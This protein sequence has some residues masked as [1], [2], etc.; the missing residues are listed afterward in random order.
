MIE[1]EKKIQK[2]KVNSYFPPFLEGFNTKKIKTTFDDINLEVVSI[3]ALKLLEKIANEKETLSETIIRLVENYLLLINLSKIYNILFYD[4]LQHQTHS[5]LEKMKTVYTKRLSGYNADFIEQLDVLIGDEL[6]SGKEQA[7][8]RKQLEKSSTDKP[9]VSNEIILPAL[10]HV[11]YQDVLQRTVT[12]GI[13]PSNILK[14]LNSKSELGLLT[15]T[16]YKTTMVLIEDEIRKIIESER[17]KVP[18]ENIEEL[19]ARMGK[20]SESM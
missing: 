1:K 13:F 11:S 7:M 15:I 10:N 12:D 5:R 19:Y 16:I 20:L 8:F 4:A 6:P 3:P 17:L 18:A 14:K 2:V 9:I